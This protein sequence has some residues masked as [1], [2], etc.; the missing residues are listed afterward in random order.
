MDPP[1]PRGKRSPAPSRSRGM[2]RVWVCPGAPVL[3]VLRRSDRRVK[4]LP[5]RR[6]AQPS[7]C[8]RGS[9]RLDRSAPAHP[10]A[11]PPCHG[12]PCRSDST[13]LRR[14]R[15]VEGRCHRPVPSCTPRRASSMMP[16]EVFFTRKKW[17]P[18][19]DPTVF[20]ASRAV[21]VPQS[22]L[23]E[24]LSS[25][26]LATLFDPL[27]EIKGRDDDAPRRGPERRG[28]RDYWKGMT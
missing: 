5:G 18:H 15:G 21:V 20:H 11:K 6:G 28:P 4:P 1:R 27:S 24:A 3:S 13:E 17:L 19:S 7:L 26:S 22:V 14:A 2:P 10:S 9:F 25:A 8:P 16:L 23:L 12:S